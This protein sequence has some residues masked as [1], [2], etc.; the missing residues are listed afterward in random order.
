[1]CIRDRT[2]ITCLSQFVIILRYSR[3]SQPVERFLSFVN[4]HN[5][6]ATGLTSVLKE[7]LKSFNL[8]NK[9]I[10]QAYDGAA[11]MSGSHNGVQVQMKEYYPY[12]HY[13]HCYA[14]KLNL[15]LKKVCSSNKRIKI[16]FA[17]LSGFG[18][19]F[20]NSPKRNDMLQKVCNVHIP[21]ICQTRWNFHSKIVNCM[22]E[23]KKQLLE[24]FKRI[25]NEDCWDDKSIRESVGFERLLEDYEFNFFLSFFYETLK[26]TDILYN[27][28][29]SNK[30]NNI[31][32]EDALKH[33]ES[34]IT[35]IR[36]NIAKFL[37]SGDDSEVLEVPLKRLKKCSVVTC[38]LYTSPS[39]RDS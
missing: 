26:H 32:V 7:E 33:F 3:N 22:K 6:T 17:N 29:Q 4:I 34:S 25:Q 38:L 21:K 11:V 18:A 28:L 39:P 35:T 13:V 30:S 8:T 14:H 1:M 37:I 27:V 12:A 36:H 10:A 23:N 16:F 15:I 19:F 20:T 24:C 9:L 5:R 2:D 31:T